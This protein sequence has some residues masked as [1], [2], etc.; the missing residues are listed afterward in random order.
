[1]GL[2]LDASVKE[3]F[4]YIGF[5][6]DNLQE[7]EFFSEVIERLHIS[8]IGLAKTFAPSFIKRPDRLSKPAGLVA[9]LK[10]SL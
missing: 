1:M 9:K 7:S 6:F 8:V 5:N 4:L 3:P 2:Q 10:E